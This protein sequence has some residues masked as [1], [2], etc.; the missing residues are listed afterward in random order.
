MKFVDLEVKNHIGIITFSRSPV[1][2][3]SYEANGEIASMFESINDRDDI[4]VVIFNSKGKGFVAGS[5]INDFKNF[6]D[7]KSLGVYEDANVRSILAIYNCK[8]P[9]IAAVHGYA[10]GLGVCLAATCDILV[11]S[12]DAYFGQPE[13]KIGTV[14][15]TGSLSLLM[16]EKFVRYMAFTGKYISAKKIAEFGSIYAVV[17]KEELLKT[18][19]EVA[20]EISA[21]YT[22]TVQAVKNAIRDLKQHDHARDF[23]CDC[24]YTHKLLKDPKR[25]EALDKFYNKSK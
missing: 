21:N 19:F 3:V 11:C 17:Q 16:P 18:A 12:T 22:G 24:K 23:Y 7:E 8:V 15:G 4:Y 13:V 10:L 20:E 1:N 2:A 25:K 5:D 9:V 6:S 14:G